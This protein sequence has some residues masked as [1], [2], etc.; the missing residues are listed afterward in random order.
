[1]HLSVNRLSLMEG[2]APSRPSRGCTW[3]PPSRTRRMALYNRARR[4]MAHRVATARSRSVLVDHVDELAQAA[5]I[6]A[7]ERA[8]DAVQFGQL[9]IAF[10]FREGFSCPNLHI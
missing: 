4:F 2:R 10:F 5:V 1:M 9:R 3:R 7:I 8:D 6:G